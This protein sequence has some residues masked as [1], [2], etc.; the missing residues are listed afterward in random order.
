VLSPVAPT[1]NPIIFDTAR[2]FLVERSHTYQQKEI[3][4]FRAGRRGESNPNPFVILSSSDS[5]MCRRGPPLV[6]NGL[7]ILN[8][9]SPSARVTAYNTTSEA[10]NMFNLNAY[11]GISLLSVQRLVS[12]QKHCRSYHAHKERGKKRFPRI[13]PLGGF[14]PPPPSK[15]IYYPITRRDEGDRHGPRRLMHTPGA[16]NKL[17]L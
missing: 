5:Q 1:F 6:N 8:C 10:G 2:L 14:E 16:V 17:E 7:E 4:A 12:C 9:L 3:R 11:P 13:K 15:T